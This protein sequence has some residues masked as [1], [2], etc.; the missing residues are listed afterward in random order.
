MRKAK[1]SLRTQHRHA[2]RI[3]DTSYREDN[4]CNWCGKPVENR[5]VHHGDG[6]PFNNDV[7]NLWALCSR[8]CHWNV[9]EQILEQPIRKMGALTG[10]GGRASA[11]V[12]TSEEQSRRA[13]MGAGE[14]KAKGARVAN[15][16]K[17]QCP[18]CDRIMN[19]G[20]L[21]M[22]RRVHGGRF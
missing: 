16:K 5:L 15:A 12:R 13:K 4:F 19:P 17:V 7:N 10:A 8:T 1:P 20:A 9:H 18:S 11:L 14:C 3:F 21:G 22:H 6:D 2:N